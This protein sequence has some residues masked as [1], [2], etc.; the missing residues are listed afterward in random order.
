MSK[1]GLIIN[2]EYTTRVKKKTFIV[3]T[4]LVP[5]LLAGLMSFLM[6]LGV[7]EI[8]HIRVLVA[9]PVN[10]CQENIF[11]GQD[12]DPPASFY[13]YQDMLL[14][15]DFKYDSQYEDYDVFVALDPDVITNRQI[16]AVYREEPSS[17]IQV[18]IHYKMRV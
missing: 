15:E 4:V 1:L 2:R 9:D 11:I 13:F 7:K 8:K 16:H 10:I 6:W 17:G 5:F 12:E 14:V 3:V 18:Y